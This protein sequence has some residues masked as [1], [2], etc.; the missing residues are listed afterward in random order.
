M[1]DQKIKLVFFLFALI[2]IP[3][4]VYARSHHHG[5]GGSMPQEI[6]PPG[7]KVIVV[8]PSI[9]RFGAYTPDGDLV[10]SG[11]ATSGSNWC[12]DLHK[13]CHT[14]VGSFRIY[15]L[16]ASNCKSHKFPLPRGGA[17]MPYCMFFNGGQGLHGSYEVVDGNASH[18]CVR[19]HVSDAKWI[20]FNFAEPGTRVIVR[21][22]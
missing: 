19:L 21:P 6:S 9:H 20:R 4:S 3:F 8:D 11:V 16:G 12:R 18:G 15:S 2:L 22:Y 13:P 10:R 5:G 7:E 1:R 17:P 14:K